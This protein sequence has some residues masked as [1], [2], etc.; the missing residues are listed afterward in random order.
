MAKYRLNQAGVEK[1]SKQVTD[2]VTY[3]YSEM[4]RLLADPDYSE[5]AAFINLDSMAL[6]LADGDKSDYIEKRKR[7]TFSELTDDIAQIIVNRRAGIDLDEDIRKFYLSIDLKIT[8]DNT[9]ID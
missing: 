8:I 1:I 7:N 6:V 9:E 4:K 2:T 5:L 3:I